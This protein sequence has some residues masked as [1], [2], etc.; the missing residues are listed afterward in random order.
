[1]AK[2]ALTDRVVFEHGQG[3]DSE[4]KRAPGKAKGPDTCPGL[5]I[6]RE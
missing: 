2:L 3:A 4:M 1:L 6:L 5:V